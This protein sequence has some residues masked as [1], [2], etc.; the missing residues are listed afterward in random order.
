M[1]E[2]VQ[3]IN[4]YLA[5]YILTFLLVGTGIFFTI[6]TRFVQVRCFGEG[7]KRVFGGFSLSGGK[8]HGGIAGVVIDGACRDVEDITGDSHCGSGGNRKHRRSL[9]SYPDWR[10]WRYFLDVDHRI[11]RNVHYLH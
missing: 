9:W 7:M 3:T 5:D 1:L 11:P 10:P 2:I 6:K 8:H 4:G